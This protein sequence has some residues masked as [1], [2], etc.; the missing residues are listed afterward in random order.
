MRIRSSSSSSLVGFVLTALA[1]CGA[2]G[3]SASNDVQLVAE[4]TAAADPRFGVSYRTA[5][6]VEIDENGA[7]FNRFTVHV[8]D[9]GGMPEAQRA[10]RFLAQVWRAANRRFSTLASGLRRTPVDVWLTRTGDAGGEQFRTNLYIYDFASERTGIEWAREL[11]HEYGHYLLPGASGYTSP[12]SWSNGVLGERLFLR[13]LRDD[14]AARLI[15]ADDLP[16]VKP[17]DLDDFCAKQSAPLTDRV[18]NNGPDLAALERTDKKGMDAF[19]SL[20]LYMDDMYGPKSLLDL[21]DYL[22]P[23]SAAGARGVDFLSAFQKSIA[24]SGSG[25]LRLDTTRPDMVFLPAGVLE[26]RADGGGQIAAAVAHKKIASGAGGILRIKRAAPGW[27]SLTVAGEGR[28]ARVTW[29]RV[30]P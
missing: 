17:G 8:P 27:L 2:A 25:S 9:S 4:T 10:G 24:S 1:L 20:M 23:H 28:P 13:W 15:S 18:R 21:L 16:Y 12:E 19:S 11:A 3:A 26:L 7:L 22:D 14:L 30:S 29:K 5:Y 6:R